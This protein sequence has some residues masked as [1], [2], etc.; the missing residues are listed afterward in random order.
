MALTIADDH[1]V[2]QESGFV[3]PDCKAP[4]RDLRCSHCEQRYASVDDFPVLF[5]RAPR[6]SS[7]AQLG[8]VYDD[9]YTARSDVWAEQG[10]TPAF[11]QFFSGL[12]NRRA[13]QRYLEIGCGEGFLLSAIAAPEKSA[14]D[15]SAK[16]LRAARGRTQAELCLALA[17]RLPFPSSHFDVVASVGVMEH[18]LDHAAVAREVNRVLKPDGHY[19]ALVHVHLTAWDRFL[20]FVLP[21]PRPLA[22]ARSLAG[23][24]VQRRAPKRRSYPK[25]PIQNHFTIASAKASLE[26]GGLRVSDV[27]HTGRYPGLPLIAPYVVVYLAKKPPVFLRRA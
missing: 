18:F 12:V 24:L 14:I 10:R 16:A 19:L 7:A 1:G 2:E 21:R 17:E 3:C 25:Q 6:F 9:I 4:L 22:L 5:S 26:G 23:R 27:L 15:L 11:L 8:E 13:P 20:R